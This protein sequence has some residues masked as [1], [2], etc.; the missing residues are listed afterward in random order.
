MSSP[1]GPSGPSVPPAAPGTPGTPG[2]DP[3]TRERAHL[4]ASRSA[5]RAMREDVQALDIKDV[6]ANWV[7]AAALTHQI[8]ERI[9]ALADL[10][11]TPCSSAASTTCT[12]PAPS[13]PR[14][15]RGSARS[16]R[17]LI[18]HCTSAGGTSTTRTATR[19]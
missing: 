17:L 6:T 12:P 11:D 13:R 9:K 5:L 4:A 7:N 14:G 16:R 2:S 19:W 15:R 10:S 18:R 3:L 1:S 8:E